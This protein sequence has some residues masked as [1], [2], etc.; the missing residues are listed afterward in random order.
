[1]H[2]KSERLIVD[3]GP[4]GSKKV[5]L[6]IAPGVYKSLPNG[7]EDNT[8]F[9]EYGATKMAEFAVE[10]IRELHLDLEKRLR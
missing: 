1:M 9:S 8:H 7:R 4:E 2:R 5:F 6:S 3:L 10:G